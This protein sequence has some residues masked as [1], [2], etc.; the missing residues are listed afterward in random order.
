MNCEKIQSLSVDFTN[1]AIDN[2]TKSKITQ[3]L[4]SCDEC[5]SFYIFTEK[6]LNQI[7]SEKISDNIPHFYEDVISRATASEKTFHIPAFIKTSVAAAAIIIAIWGGNYF[8]RYSSESFVQEYTD[9]ITEDVIDEDLANN[10]FDL[11]NNF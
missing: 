5:K 11:F 9:I 3:H 10:N 8:G 4:E 2:T 1:K 7:Q 6:T